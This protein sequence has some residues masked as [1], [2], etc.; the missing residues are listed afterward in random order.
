[1]NNEARIL[2][3]LLTLNSLFNNCSLLLING[4]MKSADSLYFG[5][6]LKLPSD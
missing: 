2:D 3:K 4:V 5:L 6:P 1:M